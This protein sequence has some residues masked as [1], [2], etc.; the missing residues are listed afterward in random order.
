V[1]AVLRS[2]SI[3]PVIGPEADGCEIAF[4]R[5]SDLNEAALAAVENGKALAGVEN[6]D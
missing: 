3:L 6:S 4:Y 1:K 2:H 5:R